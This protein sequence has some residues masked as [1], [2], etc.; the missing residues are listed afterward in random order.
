MRRPRRLQ[1]AK[2]W[3]ASGAQVTV[4]LY[5]RRYAVDRY[6]AYDELTRLGVGLPVTAARWAQR[7][8]P[9]PKARSLDVVEPPWPEVAGDEFGWIE[10]GGESILVM[11]YTSGG[12]PYGLRADDFSDRAQAAVGGS[13]SETDDL[14][15]DEDDPWSERMSPNA[16]REPPTSAL[17]VATDAEQARVLLTL[18]T[19]HPEMATEVEELLQAQR[20]TSAVTGRA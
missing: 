7:P 18:L 8:P 11:G 17:A 14:P 12:A 19:R 13:A 20:A 3:L 4:G 15:R 16:N 10:W 5:A 2:A 9:V 1:D 6:T